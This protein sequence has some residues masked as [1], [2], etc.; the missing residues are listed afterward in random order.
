LD[1]VAHDRAEVGA[2]VRVGILGPLRPVASRHW[3]ASDYHAVI[4]PAIV[5]VYHAILALCLSATAEASNCVDGG[6]E[7]SD[8]EDYTADRSE[9]QENG[10][11]RRSR[12]RRLHIAVNAAGAY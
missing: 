5:V 4:V 11:P 8:L 9:G 2:L 10:I 3:I 7:Y 12:I 6:V 1:L